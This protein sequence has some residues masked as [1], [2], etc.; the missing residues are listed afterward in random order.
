[1]R[2]FRETFLLAPRELPQNGAE[3]GRRDYV[4]HLLRQVPTRLPTR[5]W[6][7]FFLNRAP[8]VLELA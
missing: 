3:A 5:P 7:G 1:M 2:F 8:K 4:T 6:R